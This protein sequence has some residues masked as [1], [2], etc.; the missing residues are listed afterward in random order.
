VKYEP[1][2]PHDGAAESESDLP[3]AELEG[4]FQSKAAYLLKAPK[5]A[6]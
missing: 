4:A 5:A 3:P 2:L 1:R 6:K